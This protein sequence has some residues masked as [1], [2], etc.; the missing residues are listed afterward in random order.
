MCESCI[1]KLDEF[2]KFKEMLLNILGR[3]QYSTHSTYTIKNV[4]FITDYAEDSKNQISIQNHV[5]DEIKI[6]DDNCNNFD[7]N[8]EAEI[9]D[10][11]QSLECDNKND[12]ALQSDILSCNNKSDYNSIKTN[13]ECHNCNNFFASFKNLQ[14]HQ[15]YCLKRKTESTNQNVK[16]TKNTIIRGRRSQRTFVCEVCEEQFNKV[17]LIIEHY[18]TIHDYAPQ[19]IKPFACN[20]C[21]QKFSSSTLLYQ[22]LKY[23][24]KDR[25]K[26]CPT[27]GKSFITTCDLLS[28]Q[29][30]HLN[31]RN[32]KCKECH[33]GFNTNKNLRT[34]ILVVH[35]DRSAWKYHCNVCDKRFPQKSN[36]DQ[37]SKRHTGDKQHVCH[38]CQKP[39]IS[40]SELKRHVQLHSNIKLFKCI[41]CGT[42]YKTKRSHKQHV[43]RKHSETEKK[44]NSNKPE[45]IFVCHICPSRFSEKPKLVRHL[46]RHSGLKPY[47]CSMCDK[48]FSLKAYLRQH[49][50]IIH[51]QKEN[52][53]I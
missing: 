51:G 50:K 41:P 17:K 48:T 26:M 52:E 19:T 3:W 40:S 5:Q 8:H 30:T 13:N 34:H 53:L 39:F 18:T 43:N 38:I 16:E 44:N 46:S 33:K 49:L 11:A 31:R 7:N 4:Y 36:F 27:C 22:H 1:M 9:I 20:R 29:Y 28:H 25:S 47:G 45:K 42:E 10:D 12:E 24:D 2:L 35:T 6:S 37:H 14:A 15:K 32:Y 23:H 21:E